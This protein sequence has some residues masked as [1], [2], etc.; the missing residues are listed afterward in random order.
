M[1]IADGDAARARYSGS[2]ENLIETLRPHIH[3][4]RW[5][6]YAEDVDAKLNKAAVV[7]KRGLLCSLRRLQGNLSFTQASMESALAEIL[8]TTEWVKPEEAQ[9]WCEKNA[10]RLRVMLRHVSQALLKSKGA[11]PKWLNFLQ[12]ESVHPTASMAPTPLPMTRQPPPRAPRKRR[13]YRLVQMP[14]GLSQDGK[15]FATDVGAPRSCGKGSAPPAGAVYVTYYDR[16]QHKAFRK[17]IGVKK[18]IVEEA[19]TLKEPPNARDTDSMIGVFGDEEQVVE[20]VLVGEYRKLASAL[21][22]RRGPAQRPPLWSG[23]L[24][25]GEP[26]RVARIKDHH[27]IFR[28]DVRGKQKCM[29]QAEVEQDKG[30]KVM[31]RLGEELQAGRIDIKNV[32]TWRNKFCAEEN[33]PFGLKQKTVEPT[34]VAMATGAVTE[35]TSPTTKPQQRKPMYKRPAGNAANTENAE[36]EASVADTSDDD[37]TVAALATRKCQPSA[38]APSRRAPKKRARTEQAPTAVEVA[39]TAEPSELNAVWGSF[40]MNIYG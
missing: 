30:L 24:P 19:T 4:P 23:I 9:G 37:T 16:E 18:A 7:S 5:I 39:T 6:T 22:E 21:T 25:N 20:A 32:Y 36:S 13:F 35:P 17:Q 40:T 10:K 2:V 8:K 1:S 31:S 14:I 28:L 3:G 15:T 34:K 12:E 38:D 26:M 33:V 11:A 27:Y 29:M